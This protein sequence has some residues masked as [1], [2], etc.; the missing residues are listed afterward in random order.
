MSV[1]KKSSLILLCLALALACLMG[2][3]AI[4]DASS[5]KA[6]QSEVPSSASILQPGIIITPTELHTTLHPDELLTQTLWITNTGDADLSF[7]IHEM[8]ASLSLAG[9][10]MDPI[11]LQRVNPQLQA[12]VSAKGRAQAII[13]LREKPDLSPAYLIPDKLAR[14]QYVYHRLL[15]T[16][17]HSQALFQWLESQGTQPQRLLT[18]NAIT[19]TLNTSQLSTLAANPQVRQISPNHEQSILLSSPSPLLQLPGPLTSSSQP[20]TVEW[21]IAKI[22][23]DEAWSTF[24]V[25]GQGAVVGIIDTG[26][27]YDHPALVNSYRGNLGGGLFDHNYN[28]FDFV[29]GQPVP[30]DPVGHGTMGAG[31]VSGDDGGVNQIGVAP[32]AAWIAVRACDYGCTDADLLAALAWMLAPTDLNSENPDPAKAPDVVLGMWGGGGCDNWLVPSLQALRAAGI[33]PVFSPGASGP[34]CS[35]LGSPAD[36]AETLAAGATDENDVIASFS[37]RGPVTCNP[38]LIKPDLTAPGVNIRTSNNTGGYITTSGT[39]WSAAHAAGAAAMVVSADPSLAVD[40]VGDILKSTALCIDSGQCGGGTCPDPN[41]VYGY[42]RIDVFEAVSVTL[43]TP[44]AFNL[45]WLIESPISATL[46]AGAGIAIQVTFDSTGL[47]AGN[48]TGALGIFSNDPAQPFSS[49]PVTLDVINL[50]APVIVIDP[51]SLSATLPMNGVQTDTLTISNQGDASLSFSLSEVSGTQRLDSAPVKLSISDP[52]PADTPAQV[53][54]MAQTQLLIWGQSRLIIYLR[55]QPDFSAIDHLT[56]RTGRVQYVYDQLLKLAAQ[57]DGLY[58]W[59]LTQNTQ[60]RRL[61]TANAIAATLNTTQLD[62]VLGFPQVSRVGI[63]GRGYAVSDAMLGK[64]NPASTPQI[65]EWNIAKIGADQVWSTFGIRGQ[66]AVIGVVDSGVMYNHPA[67]VSSYR[68]NLGG[69]NFDHNYNWFDFFDGQ[70]APYDDIDH[71]TFG[72]GIAVGDDGL[73]NQIGV[74]PGAHWIA[75]KALDMGGGSEESL[76][77]G[78]EWMLAPTDLSGNNPDPSKAPQVLLNMWGLGGCDN[79]FEPDLLALR[80][81]NI[82]PV[83]A[84]GG[85]GP[86]CGMAAYPG[87]SP[88]AISAGATDINDVLSG[89]SS[90][91]PSCVDGGIKPDVT[92]PGVNIRSS[93][94]DGG[95]QSGW[96]GTSFST[97]HLAGAAALLFSADPQISVDQLEQTLFD[98]ALCLDDQMYC[99]GNTCPGANNAYGHGRID[100]FEAV[101]ATIGTAFDLP[102]LAEMPISA[103]LDPGESLSISVTFDASG[104]QPGT[105]FGGIL[106]QSNDPQAPFTTLPVTLT[107]TPACEPIANLK[108]DFTP[109]DPYVGDVVTFTASATGTLPISYTWDFG[110]S[111]NA[112]GEMVTHSFV[113]AGAYMVT[114]TAENACDMEGTSIT[115]DVSAEPTL[116][117]ILL[118]LVGR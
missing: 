59:L 111:S 47:E 44:P 6:S 70:P 39:S 118:P 1:Y 32:G 94:Y 104:M 72:A 9:F 115:V 52:F 98:T 35:T 68:G 107:V 5:A 23:A 87:A 105:Y 112:T 93:T 101:S 24:G 114:L 18:A 30:Y 113:G 96:S 66:G 69:G 117:R 38:G 13:F 16:A 77:A 57:S 73:G 53:D 91:G 12:Q 64:I 14:R 65:V 15:E 90:K 79:S 89:F 45:P 85:E 63:N 41:N 43:G 4:L 76:H 81:A 60:P 75:Y 22:R 19:A 50:P 11:T 67:L 58:Q 100:V 7:T 17:S 99:G 109:P 74:A 62:T 78:L 83:F 36:Y 56:D 27:M 82:L 61:L 106:I 55:D 86:G 34:S 28:W 8:S 102:W 10:N 88:E 40:E 97:A 20:D 92:A 54:A 103:G 84:A 2:V 3:F 29:N 49:V 95:Y 46:P 26:V 21:N 108:I 33:L 31:I 110:D 116:K 25:T 37:S 48:Y 71:G 42:G 51:M 80:A